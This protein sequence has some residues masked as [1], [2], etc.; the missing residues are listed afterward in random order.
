MS[1]PTYLPGTEWRVPLGA[2]MASTKTGG[3]SGF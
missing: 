3:V 1:N 2:A